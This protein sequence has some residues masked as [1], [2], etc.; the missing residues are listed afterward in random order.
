MEEIFK[1]LA[2]NSKDYDINVFNDPVETVQEDIYMDGVDFE[3]VRQYANSINNPE[4]AEAKT[5]YEAEIA[6][7]QGEI[8]S[9]R[10]SNNS[11][12]RQQQATEVSKLQEK[13][14]EFVDQRFSRNWDH[15]DQN[16]HNIRGKQ[17]YYYP[18]GYIGIGLRVEN[19][20]E[21]TCV[22]Y[23]GTRFDKIQSILRNGFKLPSEYF[24]RT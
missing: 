4:L 22:A 13:N 20:I 16:K 12:R 10:E 11:L 8:Q 5:R 15:C 9:L 3:K 1:K 17:P 7:L 6:N 2:Y 23:Y 21:N 18:V 19:F 14:E 24:G